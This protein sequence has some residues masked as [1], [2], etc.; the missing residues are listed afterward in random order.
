[1][2]ETKTVSKHTGYGVFGVMAVLLLVMGFVL[3]GFSFSTLWE[4][5]KVILTHPSLL[6]F[7]GLKQPGQFGSAFF[8]SGLLLFVVLGIYKLTKTEL[9]GVQIA[10]AMMIVGFSFYGKNIL[11]IWWPILGVFL[12][13]VLS[14]KPLASAT[15]L[16]FFATALSPIFSVL[17]FG[18]ADVFIGQNAGLQPY[19]VTAYLLGAVFGVLGGLLLSVIAGHLP[20]LHKGYVLYNAGFAAGLAGFVINSILKAAGLGHDVFR[21]GNADV[22][23]LYTGDSYMTAADGANVQLGIL[24]LIVF[25]FF[26]VAGALLGGTKQF[27]KLVWHKAKGGN[28][29]DQFGLGS[30]LINM[31]VVGIVATAFVFLTVKGQLAGPV[32][33]CIFTAAGFAANGVTVRMYLPTMAGVFFGVFL[34]AGISASLSG[35]NFFEAGLAH[36]SSRSMLLAAIFSCGLA[37]IVGEFGI[38]AGLFVGAV[39]GLLVGN[40]G[41]LHGWMS[42]YN[43]GLSLS[44]IATFLYPIYSR[45]GAKKQEDASA[46]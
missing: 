42:L 40:V 31:G 24:L 45:M 39:H 34:F 46:A 32:F 19:T 25:A 16:A 37:P 23:P 11:N 2:A 12:H 26:I 1:M 13:T 30:S 3:S 15:A 35:G 21:N 17:A 4:G 38:L 6:D 28:F 33:G 22:A 20:S 8:N 18:T 29:V 9:Q 43:N 10:A 44:L 36:A 7:D 14:K 27:G 41:V 5:Y